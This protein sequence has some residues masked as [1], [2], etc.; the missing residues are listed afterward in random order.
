MRF[1]QSAT[2]AAISLFALAQLEVKAQ[3]PTVSEIPFSVGVLHPCFPDAVVVSGTAQL[4][5]KVEEM[6][7]NGGLHTMVHI[8]M[9]G[10]KGVGLITGANYVG[11]GPIL[12]IGNLV[13]LSGPFERTEV[14]EIGLIGQGDI[15]PFV[16]KMHAHFTVNANGE[17]TVFFTESL[18]PAECR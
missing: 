6:D 17:I 5:S 11:V 1:M 3:A 2:L 14:V 7:E 4:V 18:L 16:F 15:P 8:S 12:E 10:L 13:S 9:K